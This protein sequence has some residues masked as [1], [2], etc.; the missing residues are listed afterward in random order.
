M[1]FTHPDYTN[2]TYLTQN[3]CTWILFIISMLIGLYTTLL[4]RICLRIIGKSWGILYWGGH[5]WKTPRRI[6]ES[7]L[8]G[9][10]EKAYMCKTQGS[11][12]TPIIF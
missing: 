3:T 12:I 5:F 8:K 4:C 11:I 10:I 2:I 1:H 7:F 6:F 9:I